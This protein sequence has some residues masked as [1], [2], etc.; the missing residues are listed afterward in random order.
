MADRLGGDL[1]QRKGVQEHLDSLRKREMLMQYPQFHSLG[2]PIGSGMVENANKNVVEARL[3]GAGM[4]WER[5]HVNPMLALRNAVC[6][7]RWREMWQQAVLHHRA[8]QA[9]QRSG[10]VKQ[11]AQA[12][13]AAGNAPSQESPRSQPTITPPSPI[14][15]VSEVEAPPFRLS[16]LR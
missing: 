4:H 2:W 14:L 1:A 16:P 9:L 13:L 10:H 3:K 6:N 7:D 5:N 11:R 15:T 8:L 12:F